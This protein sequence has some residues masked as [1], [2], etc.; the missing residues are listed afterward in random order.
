LEAKFCLPHYI[1]L[2]EVRDST[3]F[4]SSRSAD[5]VVISLYA[6]RGREVR[7]FEIKHNRADWLKELRDPSKAEEIGKFCDYFYLL[8]PDVPPQAKLGEKSSII[9]KLEEIPGPWGWMVLKG[10][11][12]KIIKQPEKI[13]PAPLDRPM[14][15]SLLYA[16]KARFFAEAIKQLEATIA[17]RVKERH[18][19]LTSNSSYYQRE[20]EK[21]VKTVKDFETATGLNVQ[22]QSESRLPKLGEAVR[23]LMSANGAVGDYKKQLEYSANGARSLLKQLET[24]AAEVDKLQRLPLTGATDEE[25]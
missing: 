9:A 22:Y 16:T 12:L 14:L 11:R 1:T 23:M 4:D 20:Y 21:L 17:E 19:S 6:S 2:F 10:E 8:T 15:C 13:T 7:G 24:A 5:A 3:G 25:G 18:A